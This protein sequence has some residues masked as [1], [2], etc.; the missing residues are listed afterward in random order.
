MDSG[1]IA[2]VAVAGTAGVF[3]AVHL[4]RRF[5]VAVLTMRA[6]AWVP[7]LSRLLSSWVN[8]HDYSGDAFFRADGANDRIV[9]RRLEALD[10]L[11]ASFTDAHAK[12]AG[13]GAS[14]RDG[15][16]DIRFA[17]ANRVPFPFAKTMREKFDLTTVVTE[18]DGPH[19]R[20]LD[21]HWSLDVSGSYGVNVAGFE[22]Y[23][24]W[25]E[26]GWSRVK[27]L[28][29]V[30]GPVHPI[31][32]DNIRMLREISDL[33]EVSFHMSGTE[34]VMAAVRLARFNTRRKLIVCFSGAYHGWWDG[35]VAG[36]GSDRPL[37][38]C[39][40]LKDLDPASLE[41]IRRRGHEIAAVLVNP[42]QSFH[43][44]TPPPN[45]A[46][47]LTSDVRKTEDSRDR[48]TEWLKQLRLVVRHGQRSAGVR[49]GLHR[50]PA[51][52]RWR[53][54][55]LRREGR[56]GR[57]WQDGGWWAAHR[58]GLRAAR[59]DAT[60]RST[61]ADAARVRRRHL[62]GA[63]GGHGCDVRIPHLGHGAGPRDSV[64]GH[65]SAVRRVGALDQCTAGR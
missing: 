42:I 27:A 25:I 15:F 23:K 9:R 46:V 62:L 48:Y 52:R 44:N 10:R 3:L 12:S 58:R 59:A 41:V 57:V 53:A 17:D 45:D 13:W 4:L 21:G 37:D 43:P 2:L 7:L 30:L 1:L 18:S 28:G 19:L 24:E 40:T 22:R 56:R 16:S 26:R 35:V 61:A 31:V 34:A 55:I 39:L 38:D 5:S 33:D 49:R 29:P 11:S 50:V 54:G 36:L 8:A 20:D 14:V 60:I 32:A 64:R 65:E 63:S 6:R 47:L 51:C